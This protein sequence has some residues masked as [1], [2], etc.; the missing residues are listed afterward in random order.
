[1]E[2]EVEVEVDVEE[3]IVLVCRRRLSRAVI[4]LA[5]VRAEGV[6]LSSSV[7]LS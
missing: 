6:W 3:E 1:M 2:A 7:E 4:A 5:M